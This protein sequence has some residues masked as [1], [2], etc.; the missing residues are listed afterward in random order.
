MYQKIL[1]YVVI[2]TYSYFFV[3]KTTFCNPINR[4]FDSIQLSGYYQTNIMRISM[5]LSNLFLYL[6]SAFQEGWATSLLSAYYPLLMSGSSLIVCFWAEVSQFI[7]FYCSFIKCITKYFA[8][9]LNIT[10]KRRQ[11]LFIRRVHF[12]FVVQRHLLTI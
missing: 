8:C 3:F 5:F 12:N 7:Q 1:N 4:F 9:D 2:G 11:K 10:R 6:Q